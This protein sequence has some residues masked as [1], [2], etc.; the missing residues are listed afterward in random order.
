MKKIAV[1][2]IVEIDE[3]KCDGCGRCVP[4]CAEGAIRI[5][6]GKARLVAENL[7]DGLG[8]CLGTCPKGAITIEVRPAQEFDERAVQAH[9]DSDTKD[10]RSHSPPVPAQGGCPG[11]MMRT[12]EQGKAPATSPN[13]GEATEAGPSQLRHWPV[14]LALLPVSSPIW[15]GADVLLAA[16]CVAVAMPG[17]QSRLLAGKTV[18]VACPKLDDADPY[19]A[20]LAQIFA[21]NDIRSVTIAHMEVPCCFALNRIVQA[22][23]DQAGRM[24]IPVHQVTVGID[25]GV[26]EQAPVTDS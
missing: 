24:D 25:G 13:A 18:A 22:A 14:Q 15:A 17:F 3:D 6:D 8:N 23:M 26:K 20:K 4:S 5:I 21:N 12:L 7:C 10:S 19:V 1:R 9:A 16:D 2:K 11:A